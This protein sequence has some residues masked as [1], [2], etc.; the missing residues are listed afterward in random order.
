VT[1][2]CAPQSGSCAGVA[3]DLAPSGSGGSYFLRD[4]D[5]NVVAI[6]KPLDEEPNMRNNP[7]GFTAVCSPE[8]DTAGG[9]CSL[10]RGILPGEGAHREIAAYILDHGHRAGV[11]ATAPVFVTYPD[12]SHKY[13]SLQQFVH[14]DTTCDDLGYSAFSVAEVHKIAV[15]DLRLANADRNGGNILA[16]RGP[17]GEWQLT[18]IDHGYCLPDTWQDMAFEWSSWR[19]VRELPSQPWHSRGA[20]PTCCSTGHEQL[21]SSCL[22]TTAASRNTSVANRVL[23][24]CRRACRSTRRRASS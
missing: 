3:P 22:Y 14:S 9:C 23:L 2:V 11:P 8:A 5:R 10:R 19:Q 15:L 21:D 7:R 20:Q 17:E 6:F 12:G 18:P 16:R 1:S 13:G 24:S 4:T